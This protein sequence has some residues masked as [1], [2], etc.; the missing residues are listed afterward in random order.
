MNRIITPSSLVMLLALA[1]GSESAEQRERVSGAETTDMESGMAADL[2]KVTYKAQG[3]DGAEGSKCDYDRSWLQ[4]TNLKEPIRTMVNEALDHDPRKAL[5]ACKNS[6]RFE[7]G[8]TKLDANTAGVLSVVYHFENFQNGAAYSDIAPTNLDLTTGKYITLA[9]VIDAAGKDLV[10]ASCTNQWRQAALAQ[11]EATGLTVTDEP[12]K[13]AL[14]LYPGQDN[15]QFSLSPAGILVHI[16]A[17]IPRYSLKLL[18]ADGFLVPWSDIL[19]ASVL[20]GPAK[21][22][23]GT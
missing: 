22:L 17:H 9:Q 20:A 10:V 18:P 4:V 13:E 23:S 5:D 15:E 21:R 7:G 11:G 16:D 8:Y 12:C 2:V 1:C 6:G 14:T 19:R 3:V